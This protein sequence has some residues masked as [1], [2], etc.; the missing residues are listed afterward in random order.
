MHTRAV[1]RRPAGIGGL[2]Q[3]RQRTSEKKVSQNLFRQPNVIMSCSLVRGMD[4]QCTYTVDALPFW[5]ETVLLA[6]KT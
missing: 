1:Q 3:R 4:G 5:L 6:P 2:S